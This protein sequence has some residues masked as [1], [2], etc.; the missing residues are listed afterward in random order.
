M[1]VERSK[2]RLE[3]IEMAK[4]IDYSLARKINLKTKLERQR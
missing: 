4:S 1:R 3:S 2:Y